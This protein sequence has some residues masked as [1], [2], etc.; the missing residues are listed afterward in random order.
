MDNR[1]SGTPRR[2]DGGAEAGPPV[3]AASCHMDGNHP[4]I[5][6]DE[7]IESQIISGKVR[8]RKSF[9]FE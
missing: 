2:C 6:F 4:E 3:G 5:D 1:G 9:P 7:L 8:E